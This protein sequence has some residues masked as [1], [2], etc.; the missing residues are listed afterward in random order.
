MKIAVFIKSTT[1]HK[2][3]GG[4]EIQNKTICEEF[5]KRGHLITVF[6]LRKELDYENKEE[7]GVSY[8]FINA[9]YTYRLLSS[10]GSN[11][12]YN[13]SLEVFTKYH[14]KEKFDLVLSQ[15]SSA[16]SIIEKKNELEV[17][18]VSISHGTAAS[19]YITFVKNMS[20]LKDL[21]WL[22]RNTQYFIRQYFGKQR[23]FINHSNKVI[24]VS[25]YVKNA[26]IEET[27]VSED[28]VV[29]IH[30]GIDPSNY[31]DSERSEID[32]NRIGIYFIGR[33][34]KS[35][36]I[37]AIL[38]IV[39]GVDLK[40]SLHVIGDGPD[41][42]S[43]KRK[44][45]LLGISDNVIFHGRYLH[46]E[47][48]K[49]FK[50]DIFVFPT[51]RIEGFPMVLVES[52]FAG[53]PVVAFNMGGVFDAVEDGKTGYLVKGGDNKE[54]RKKLLDLMKDPSLRT[55]F[56]KNAKEKAENQFRLD[57]MIDT[58]ES[59]FREVLK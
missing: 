12:W 3:H 18:V 34:E 5:V 37:F 24:A 57:K 29:V 38:D 20:G 10:F 32:K 36:G 28:K 26:L 23:R 11:S 50:P 33:V 15:S 4:L 19:E 8:V 21:F 48:I 16:E 43:A 55:L 42:E 25:N 41:L 30:N 14:E 7:N 1:F 53:M 44:A 17:K 47:F 39:K 22:M 45:S 35:K 58:Y 40:Y 31:E 46:N 6:S 51:K 52:M 56:G 27:F 9:S 13:K 54:F 59:I 2:G 49:L